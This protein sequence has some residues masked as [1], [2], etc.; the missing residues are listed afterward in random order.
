MLPASP[1]DSVTLCSK[2]KD[3]ANKAGAKGEP[4]TPTNPF[5]CESAG[6]PRRKFQEEAKG[7]LMAKAMLE[8]GE[9]DQQG[10]SPPTAACPH[11][12]LSDP[13]VLTA[14]TTMGNP[15]TSSLCLENGNA[16]GSHPPTGEAT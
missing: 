3:C 12:I 9:T 8:A 1:A 10:A 14:V 11:S 5:M 16:P 4:S 2:I 15:V 13:P 7:G 6:H